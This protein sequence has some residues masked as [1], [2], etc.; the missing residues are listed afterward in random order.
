MG[1]IGSFL[2]FIL[3]NLFMERCLGC[4]ISIEWSGDDRDLVLPS[5]FPSGSADFFRK[6]HV[7][8]PFRPVEMSA[9]LLCRSCWLRLTPVFESASPEVRGV[10]VITPFRTTSLLLDTVKY[11]KYS[12]GKSAA[13]TLSWWMAE[14]MLHNIGGRDALSGSGIKLVPVPLHPYR[15]R[16]RGYNQALLLAENAGRRLGLPVRR[17]LITRVRRTRSQ[18]KLTPEKRKRNVA[19]AFR[20]AGPPEGILVLVDDIVTTGETAGECV[21]VLEDSGCSVLAVLA[22]GNS[23]EE[24]EAGTE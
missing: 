15:K 18:T 16:R 20:P 4:G 2:S 1:S 11:L 12:G 10:P 9:R 21:R 23:L 3:S 19:G 13:V 6:D 17:D 22:A 14:A 8:S 24:K 5:G 7:F